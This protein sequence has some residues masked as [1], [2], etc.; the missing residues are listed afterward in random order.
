VCTALKFE[1]TR[2]VGEDLTPLLPSELDAHSNPAYG[3]R[4]E[5]T[6]EAPESN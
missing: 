4:S 2:S 5:A 6:H 3:T 1:F